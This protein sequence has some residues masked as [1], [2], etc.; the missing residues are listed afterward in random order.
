MPVGG[1]SKIIHK[2]DLVFN[3]H[4]LVCN[5]TILFSLCVF[6]FSITTK[7]VKQLKNI[8]TFSA[9]EKP[10]SKL[11]FGYRVLGFSL[12]PVDSNHGCSTY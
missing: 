5:A 11:V 7:K 4:M 8:N 1:L 3:K 12:P 6:L 2:Q 10:F 9:S